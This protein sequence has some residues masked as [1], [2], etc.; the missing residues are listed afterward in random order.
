MLD[1]RWERNLEMPRTS[2]VGRKGILSWLKHSI[3][4][5]AIAQKIGYGYALAIGLA[6]SGTAIGSIVGDRY[7]NQAENQLIVANR[8]QNLLGEL[9]NAVLTV[10]SHPQQLVAVVEDSIWFEYETSEFL[11]NVSWVQTV[12]SELDEFI[13]GNPDL[14][15]IDPTEFR[16]VLEE[17]AATIEAYQQFIQSLWSQIEQTNEIENERAARQRI[18]NALLDREALQLNV[19]FEKLS[20]SHI[21]I[22]QA[23]E[24]TQ[25]QA[26][27][28][29]IR[30]DAL[31]LQI[32]TASMV[33]SVA[34]AA[35]LAMYT[36]R[37]IARPI[38]AVTQ[39]ARQVTQESNFNLQ[40]TVTTQDEVGILALSL[41]QLVQ[42]VGEYT[43][44]LEN[45][46]QISEQR[47]EELHTTLHKLKQT[48]AQLIQTEKMSSLG[49]LVAG[50]AHE[51]NNPINFIYGN[52][53]HVQE[54]ARDLLEILDLYQAKCSQ[55]SPD[56]QTRID[57][58]DPDYIREDFPKMLSSMKMGADRIKA[59]VLS[60]RNFSRLDE[61]EVKDASLHEGIDST[62][63]ILKSQLK[64]G[65]EVI[66]QYG[67]L[68]SISCYPAQLNQVFMNL[69]SNAIDAMIEANSQP[70]QLSIRTEHIDNRVFVGIR[71]T[72]PGIPLAVREKIFDPFFTTKPV[73]KGTGLG[74]SIC[75]QIV[76]KHQ[77]TIEVTSE[78]G[79]GTEF[80]ISLPV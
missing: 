9:D 36:S 2:I 14:V 26:N 51:I 62:L 1:V 11:G 67:D 25:Q 19:Q 28:G 21:R 63:L 77:G 27:T 70:K 60:L 74:L 76:E 59:M 39:V 37:G 53:I 4:N 7:Q 71:D 42:W 10:R 43:H 31:R 79:Q 55:L 41:N 30:A 24:A 49:Q 73:G 3:A 40:A 75:Y 80:T 61:A 68:P 48:Q 16:T 54:Y 57:D 78:I 46:R 13:D 38:Q 6:V 8:Q 44:E 64:R 18:V 52:L 15:A 34:I 22:L 66:K 5:L 45:A 33:L 69:F 58:L 12:L 56:V 23:A 20:E 47:V 29:L 17:Y 65:V 72:G 32:V 50:V 35:A